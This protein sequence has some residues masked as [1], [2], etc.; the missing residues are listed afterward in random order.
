MVNTRSTVRDRQGVNDGEE[1]ITQ[2]SDETVERNEPNDEFVQAS[3]ISLPLMQFQQYW[4]KERAAL[5]EQLQVEWSASLGDLREAM[6][7][8]WRSFLAEFQSLLTT[9]AANSCQILE[10]HLNPQPPKQLAGFLNKILV[11][12]KYPHWETPE[13]QS[14]ETYS[15]FHKQVS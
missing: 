10:H 9:Q 14:K 4:E 12:I 3:G 13:G 15:D 8:D 5:V 1:T 11:L 6:Q 7:E 2:S